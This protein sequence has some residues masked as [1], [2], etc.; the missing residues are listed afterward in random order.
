MLTYVGPIPGGTKRA[1]SINV[2]LPCLQKD[3]SA[4][5]ISRDFVIFPIVAIFY[6]F[7]QFCEINISLLSL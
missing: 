7:S 1:T 6:P 4:G 3:L 5:P 2:Q